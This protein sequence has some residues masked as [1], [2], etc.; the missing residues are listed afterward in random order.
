MRILFAILICL[1]ISGPLMAAD[2]IRLDNKGQITVRADHITSNDNDKTVLARGEVEI[3]RGQN[4]LYADEVLINT[5][6]MQADAIGNVRFTTPSEIMRGSRMLADLNSGLGKVYEAR[7]FNRPTNFYLNGNEIER[8]GENVYRIKH[9]DIT[10]CNDESPPWRFSSSEINV[11]LEGY[12]TFS[13]TTFDVMGVPTLWAPWF[14]FPVKTERQ[15]GLLFP[16]FG[17]SDRDGFIA[18]QS[19]F[20]TLGDSQDL[21]LTANFMSRRGVDWGLEYRYSLNED[22]KGMFMLDIM[23]EDRRGEDLFRDGS[24][25]EAYNTRYWIRGKADHRLGPKTTLRLDMDIVS[26]RDYL[27][28]FNFSET[29]FSTSRQRFIDWFRRDIDTENSL[30]RTNLLNLNHLRENE[31][32]NLGLRYNDRLDAQDDI[33]M[34]DLPQLSWDMARTPIADSPLFFQMDSSYNYMYSRAESKGSILDLAPAVALPVNLQDYIMIEPRFTW[35]PQMFKLEQLEDEYVDGS[36]FTDNVNFTIDASSYLYN[37]YDLGGDENQYLLRHAVRPKISYSYQ[38]SL[39]GDDLP[40]L[41]NR[42]ATNY[43]RISYGLDNSLTLKTTL[44]ADD[45]AED[46]TK[47]GTGREGITPTRIGGLSPYLIGANMESPDGDNV[48]VP[49]NAA[50]SG[51]KAFYSEFLRFNLSHAFYFDPYVE[52]YTNEERDW[53]NIE[54]RLEIKPFDDYRLS[55]TVDTA[56]D[57]YRGDFDEISVLVST[58]NQRGDFIM[59][60]YTNRAYDIRNPIYNNPDSHGRTNQIRG[61]LHLNIGYGFSVTYNGRYDIERN[62][63]F[64]NT[65]SLNYTA[66]CWGISLIFHEDDREQGYYVAFDLAGINLFGGR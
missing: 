55:M 52:D 27:Q 49:E 33:T 44:K 3:T 60:D 40:W 1:V 59:L 22:S 32:L 24:N 43:H 64:E 38:N 56:Y 11:E 6:T 39:S 17:F 28:E 9:G 63:R 62:V 16:S 54:S 42:S 12:A 66:Q 18:E 5:E 50:P 25:A 34:H 31:S 48:N 51:A 58:R 47:A 15:S 19:Y 2:L 14:I 41:I 13:N 61:W 10:S 46:K 37:V 23:P 36:G 4:S 45:A 65:F 29:G 7:V 30:T 8:L 53:G 20:Q 26:D 35:R 57:V 21:T